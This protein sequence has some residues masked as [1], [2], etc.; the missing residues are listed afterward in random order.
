GAAAAAVGAAGA[1]GSS[2]T[3]NA[4]V[5]GGAVAG[6]TGPELPSPLAG[7]EMSRLWRAELGELRGR[8]QL[9]RTTIGVV[10]NT[11]A[12]KSSLLNALLG[13]E[14]ILPTNGMR[15]STGCPIEVSY[16]PS[17]AYQAAVEFLSKE[18]WL[19]YLER[20]VEDLRGEDG[21][22]RVSTA[23][24]CNT[25]SEAGAAQAMLEAVYGREAI[26][27]PGLT[28]ERL[29]AA[30]SAVT[31][32]LGSTL[33]IRQ[34]DRRAFRREIGRYVDSH[35][36][37]DSAQAWPLVKVCRIQHNW[38]LLSAGAVLVDLPGVRDANE[39]RG[40]VAEAYMRKLNAVWVV[41]AITRAV[42]DKTAKDLLGSSF[43]RRLMM[44]GQLDNITFVCTKTDDIDWTE[45]L[46]DL[47]AEEVC[48]RSHTDPRVF[49]AL[50]ARLE[51]L[52]QEEKAA[53]KAKAATTRKVGSTQRC[54]EKALR[55][56]RLLERCVRDS[57]RT[58][59]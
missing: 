57:C 55:E 54:C 26:R 27:R 29:R 25:R 11:G 18:E 32:L 21:T 24:E 56:A 34:H 58:A 38:K 13:E 50:E 51:S 49:A 6:A 5:A 35:N 59:E 45:T 14:D 30:R 8:C 15:A 4:A 37:A 42:D 43:R 31:A 53:K 44:D 52:R 20:L 23:G 7:P 39:A 10:G 19:P 16:N 9:P 17:P 36:Q 41:A 48:A 40:A 1:P 2:N 3:T 22:L 28:L 33:Q 12:G 46:R 47:G